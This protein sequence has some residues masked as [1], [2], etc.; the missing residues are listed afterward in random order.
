MNRNTYR[1][2]FSRVHHMLVAVEETGAAGGKAGKGEVVIA[3]TVA[4][5]LFVPLLAHAQIV[6]GGANAPK[7]ISTANGLPQVNVNR[8]SGTGV[9]VNTYNQFD[10]QKNGAIL[11]NSASNTSTQ[12]AGQIPRS[13]MPCCRRGTSA[14][15]G[16][17]QRAAH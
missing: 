17:L 10:V 6:P 14:T 13:Q 9:S 7:V 15:A 2:V 4:A 1:L 16:R 11:N 5:A 3:A 8:P 12:L